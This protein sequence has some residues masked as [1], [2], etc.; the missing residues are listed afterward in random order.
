MGKITAALHESDP[1]D[2]LALVQHANNRAVMGFVNLNRLGDAK[3]A[4]GHLQEA[5]RLRRIWLGREP[6]SDDAKLGVA[7]A[8]GQLA[9]CL[10]RLGDTS[11]ALANFGEELELRKSLSEPVRRSYEVRRE[12]SGLYEKMGEAEYQQGRPR[13]AWNWFDESLKVREELA[14]ESPENAN[15]L[16]DLYNSINSKGHEQLFG[17][18]GPAA[19]R[20]YYARAVEGFRELV[21]RDSSPAFRG[22]LALSCY[23]LATALL[24]MGEPQEAD[25]YYRE[26]LEIRRGLAQGPDAPRGDRINLAIALGRCR[27]AEEAARIG[28]VL[29]AESDL[30]A[31]DHFQIACILSI[32]SGASQGEAARACAGEAVESLRKA[33]AAGRGTPGEFRVDP[34]LEAIQKDDRFLALIAELEAKA[35][36]PP[37]G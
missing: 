11:G 27:E 18:G 32:A 29:A 21:E 6:G 37:S 2:T 30:S 33:A 9:I 34:D 24:R 31:D 35:A 23:F 4:R 22:S 19:A 5:L 3:V 17:S 25:R 13:E 7:N 1:A 10:L 14:R 8:L 36:A 26:C 16:R 15:N 12:L 20:D 28:R